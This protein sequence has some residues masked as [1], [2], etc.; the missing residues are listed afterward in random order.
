MLFE[1]ETQEQHAFCALRYA[2]RLVESPRLGKHLKDLVA[3]TRRVQLN[4]IT[5]QRS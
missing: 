2:Y 3:A 5:V 4:T 1:T